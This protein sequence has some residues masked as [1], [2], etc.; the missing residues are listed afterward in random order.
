MVY[1]GALPLL[2]RAW[3]VIYHDADGS[4]VQSP[5]ATSTTVACEQRRNRLLLP[6]LFG[7][8]ARAYS[9]TAPS[10]IMR[11]TIICQ[12]RVFSRGLSNAGV[13]VVARPCTWQGRELRPRAVQACRGSFIMARLRQVP[14]GQ[15]R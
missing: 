7:Q 13:A 5:S 14:A 8:A 4:Y 1:L 6:K 15:Y 9:V 2:V 12:P 3:K 10:G 11:Q